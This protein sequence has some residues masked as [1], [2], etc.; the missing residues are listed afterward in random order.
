VGAFRSQRL[1][2]LLQEKIGQLIVDGKIKD[3]RVD[4]FLSV[5]RVDVSS[6]LSYADVFISSFKPDGSLE[7]GI[8][9]LQSACGFIQAKLA[10]TMHVRKTPKLRFHKDSAMKE[11]FDLIKKIEALVPPAPLEPKGDA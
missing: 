8:T 1:N 4:T 7:K 11:S 3:R 9:G 6:D 5:T 2:R 10:E